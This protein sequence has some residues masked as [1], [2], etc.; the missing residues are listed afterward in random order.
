MRGWLRGRVARRARLMD[1]MMARIG[2]DPGLAALRG[3]AFAAAGRRCLWCAASQQCERW[4]EETRSAAHGPSFCPNTP[5]FEDIRSV[6]S[7]ATR[8]GAGT[9]PG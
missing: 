3:R 7:A 4:L 8:S 6:P 5:F 9:V 2:V 1:A